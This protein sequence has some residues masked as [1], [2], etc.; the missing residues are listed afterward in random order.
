MELKEIYENVKEVL[1]KE[2]HAREEGLDT[3]RDA[4]QHCANSIRAAHREDHE[5]A[6]RLLGQAESKLRRAQ[7]VLEPYPRIYYAGF[8]QDA[9]KEYAEASSTL[10]L[11]EGRD[12]PL[13]ADLGV[14]TA[15]YLNGLGEAVGEMR[16]HVLDLIRKNELDRG[17]EILTAMDDI[18]YLLASMDYPNAITAGLKRTND[19]VRGVLERTRGDLTTAIRRHSLEQALADLEKKLQNGGQT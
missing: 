3:S 6:V 17:E 12:L 1:D 16:R 18:Y 11:I 4:I 9:E 7:S 8:L 10:A 14:G 13:A 15:A 5:E 2:N 19:M